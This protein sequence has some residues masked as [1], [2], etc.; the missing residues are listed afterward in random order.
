[1]QSVRKKQPKKLY[2][3]TQ[4][5]VVFTNVHRSHVG[6]TCLSQTYLRYIHTGAALPTPLF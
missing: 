3:N 1:M 4:P 5:G 2:P 6:I